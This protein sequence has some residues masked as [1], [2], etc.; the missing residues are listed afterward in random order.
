MKLITDWG[1][2]AESWKGQRGEYWV[3]MQ[4]LLMFGYVLLPIYRP[5]WLT[6]EPPL[7]YGIWIFAG[8]LFL[9][10]AVF[11]VKGLLD[12]GQNLTPLPYPKADG[13]LIQSGIYGVVRHPLYSGIILAAKAYAIGQLSL[14]HLAATFVLFLFFNFKAKREENWL[15]EKFATYSDYQQRVKKLIPWVF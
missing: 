6:I 8:I 13:E 5:D 10:A 14:S 15:S 4:G 2:D 9:V 3:L 12:L 11:L 1:F 7:R